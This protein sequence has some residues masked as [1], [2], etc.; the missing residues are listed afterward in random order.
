[1]LKVTL[2]LREFATYRIRFKL[3][4]RRPS[5]SAASLLPAALYVGRFY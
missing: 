2:F 4:L 5:L 1:M 3:S